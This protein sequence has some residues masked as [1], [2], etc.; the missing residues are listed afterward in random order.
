M[1]LALGHLANGTLRNYLMNVLTHLRLKE[2]F[3]EHVNGLV[4]PQKGQPS[5]LH[6]PL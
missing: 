6:A 4:D 1:E 5:P 2:V 3:L